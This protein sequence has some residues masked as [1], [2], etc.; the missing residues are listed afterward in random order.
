MPNAALDNFDL[1][2]A[3]R[4]RADFKTIM[5]RTAGREHLSHIC[6]VSANG[7]MIDDAEDLS[8]GDRVSVR[9]P[10]I[11]RIEAHCVWAVD[12][13][14]GFQLERI[15]RMP[16]FIAMLDDLQNPR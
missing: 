12:S 3:A 8:R 2:Q 6:N 14:A 7:F 16:D 1:R 13:R 10:I 11:G 5:E 9:L 4:P 15:I